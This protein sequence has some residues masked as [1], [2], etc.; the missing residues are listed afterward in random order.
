[1]SITAYTVDARS[2]KGDDYGYVNIATTW[3]GKD[4]PSKPKE[5]EKIDA[6]WSHESVYGIIGPKVGDFIE[7]YGVNASLQEGVFTH[8][9]IAEKLLDLFS[10]LKMNEVQWRENPLEHTL[11]N[12][13][14]RVKKA[15]WLPEK[16]VDI[17]HLYSDTY[18][19]VRSP[20]PITTDFFTAIR[21]EKR[22]ENNWFMCTEQAKEKLESIGFENLKIEKST[23]K[24]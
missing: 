12:G 13:K 24:G 7:T 9:S 4:M 5:G 17:V 20:C 6:M 11:K 8:R 10:G 23:V 1:M 15:K 22:H 2:V 21:Q 16:E 3:K 19:D 18:I 14:P